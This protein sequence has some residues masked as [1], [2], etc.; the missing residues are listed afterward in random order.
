VDG[1]RRSLGLALVLALALV[2]ILLN[3]VT[4]DLTSGSA[5]PGVVARGPARGDRGR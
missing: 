5:G 1:S 3:V 4:N 2:S